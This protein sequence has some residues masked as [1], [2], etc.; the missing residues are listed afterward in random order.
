MTET[1]TDAADQA[2]KD[3]WTKEVQDALREERD[4]QRA[5]PES[6]YAA[7][8]SSDAPRIEHW[9][10]GSYAVRSHDV[11]AFDPILADE[12]FHDFY[13]DAQDSPDGYAIRYNPHTGENEMFVAGSH[14]FGRHPY[15]AA[16]DWGA[17]FLDAGLYTADKFM[18]VA[19]ERFQDAKRMVG[20][21][22]KPR[23]W[24]YF[25]AL[26]DPKRTAHTQELADIANANDVRVVYGFSR[27]GAIAADMQLYGYEGEVVGLSGAMS[28]AHNVNALNLTEGPGNEGE[29]DAAHPFGFFDQVVG[30]TGRHNVHYDLSPNMPHQVW[31]GKKRKWGFW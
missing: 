4:Q 27:G 16:E 21:R 9:M 12:S 3:F 1:K 28:I 11:K 7:V 13:L 29:D 6:L 14:S 19:I 18:N 10:P 2:V 22:T 26:G 23:Y 20:Y 17:N 5:D 25:G 8:H 15:R 31:K 30:M 24:G